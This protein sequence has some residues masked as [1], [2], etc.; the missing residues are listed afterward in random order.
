[1]L[2]PHF[3]HAAHAAAASLAAPVK[4]LLRPRER[5]GSGGPDGDQDD[6]LRVLMPLLAVVITIASVF[7]R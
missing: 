1:M 2:R 5:M 6:D 7:G 3:T 4:F